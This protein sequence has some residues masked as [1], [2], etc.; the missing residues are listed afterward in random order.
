MAFDFFDNKFSSNL[1]GTEWLGSVED[2]NDPNFSGRC[3]VRVFGVFDGTNDDTVENSPYVINTN[4][5]PWCYPANGIF[6]GSGKSMGAGNLSVPKIGSK[7]KVRFNGGHLYAPEYF[8]IQ[9]VNLEMADDLKDSYVDSHVILYD[10][11]QQLKI[12]YKKS[13]G[14]QIFYQ[15]SNMT[16]NPDASITIEHKDTQ[17]LIELIGGTINITANSTINITSNSKIEAVTSEGIF[18][19]NVSTKLGP[20]PQFSAVLAEPLWAF[21]KMLASAID[22]KLPSTPS[23]MSSQAAAYES[24]STSKNVKISP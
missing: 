4:D 6:F 18:N 7:V 12:L 13:L 14:F 10:K 8:A 17:S 9:D 1:R 22:A 23:A 11:D 21:L 3:K 2:N 15:G 20:S 24:I 19:G 5:L 16:I